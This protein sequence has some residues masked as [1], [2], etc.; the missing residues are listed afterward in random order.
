M[1]TPDDSVAAGNTRR[2][3]EVTSPVKAPAPAATQ[4]SQ[5]LTRT[6]RTER[7]AVPPRQADRYAVR[8]EDT[9][10]GNPKLLFALKIENRLGVFYDRANTTWIPSPIRVL[11]T[12]IRAAVTYVLTDV[13][14]D[15]VRY[16]RE[17]EASTAE[18]NVNAIVP[19]L[20]NG[21]MIA[22][23]R[24]LRLVNRL[25]ERLADRY[26]QLP[27]VPEPFKIP[28]PYALAIEHFGRFK[29]SGLPSEVYYTPTV[30]ADLVNFGCTDAAHPWSPIN[31]SRAV[32]NASKL[33]LQFST[34]DLTVKM[35][36]SWWLYRSVNVNNNIRLECPL[37]EEN[38]TESTAVVACLFCADE[39]GNP[40]NPIINNADIGNQIFGSMAR[41]LPAEYAVNCYYAIAPQAEFDYQVVN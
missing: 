8:R 32:S 2:E 21:V 29:A 33:G 36:S 7:P 20:A 40:H 30:D 5:V 19:E 35:G 9:P 34:A 28:Q 11:T 15:L 24:K 41:N 27:K 1:S 3:P 16:K 23:Y 37:P 10:V 18:F 12:N 14:N 17:Q 38:F 31:Y 26:R 4:Q 6:F 25:D 22:L 13:L 39:A